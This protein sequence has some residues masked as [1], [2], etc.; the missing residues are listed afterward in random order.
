MEEWRFQNIWLLHGDICCTSLVTFENM[1]MS[2]YYV[3]PW[4]ANPLGGSG[5]TARDE[6]FGGRRDVET[7]QVG[8]QTSEA[9][10][11]EADHIQDKTEEAYKV[12]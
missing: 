7:G 8:P 2:V 12:R 11:A 5:K 3:S 6:L 4:Q 10:L 1:L 9:K